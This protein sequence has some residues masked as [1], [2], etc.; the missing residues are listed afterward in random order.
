MDGC[1]M[2]IDFG[3]QTVHCKPIEV[4]IMIISMTPRILLVPP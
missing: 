2:D 3:Q 4:H 1:A